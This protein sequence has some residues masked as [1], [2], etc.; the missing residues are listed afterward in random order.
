MR[1]PTAGVRAGRPAAVPRPGLGPLLALLLMATPALPGPLPAQE[2]EIPDR[3]FQ[4][5]TWRNIGPY[6]GGRAVAVHGVP[7]QPETYYMGS[8]GGGV[9]KTTDGG[10]RWRNVSDGFF[11]TGSVGA[12]AVAPSDPNVVYVGMGEHPVRG[13]TT[14]HGDGVYRSTDAGETWTHLGLEGTRHISRIRVHPDDPDRVWVAAQGAVYGPSEE[15]GVYRSRDGGGS[16]EK[17]LYVGETAGASDLAL[18]PTNPRILYAAFWDHL[19][20]PWRVRSGGPG[21]G[22]WKSTDG[23]ETWEPI[24][25]GLPDLMGKTSVDVSPADPDRLYAIVEAE[26]DQGG[27]YR[28][29]DGGRSWR[30]TSDARVIQARSWYYMEVFAHPTD[31]NTVVVLNAPFNLSVDGGRTFTQVEVGHG[32]THDLWINP[33]EPERMILADDGGA[34]ITANGGESWTTLRNQPTAQF[35]RVNADA[36]FPY[37]V[38]GGQQDNSAIGIRSASFGGIGW[39]DFYPVAGCESAY[40]AFDPENPRYVYGNCYQGLIDRWDRESRRSKPV[41]PYPFLGL[42]VDPADQPYRFNWNAPVVADPHD[43]ETI[44]FA[45][46]VVFRTSDRGQSWDVISP[47]LTRDEEE[48]QGPG[49]GPIT[50]EGA[51]GE[52][53]NT[54]MYLEPSP[55]EEGTL[56]AG[57]DDGLVHLTRDGGGNWSEVTP[58]DLPEGMINSIEASPHDPAKAYVVFT[59]YKFDDFTPHVFRTRDYGRSWSRIVDGI[60]A[61][62]AWVRVVREDPE[63]E[64]LLYAGTEVGVYLSFDDGARW[65]EWQLNLPVVPVTDLLVH[66]GDLVASTQGRAFWILDELGPVRQMSA[67]AAGAPVHLFRPEDAHR[68]AWSGGFGG[69]RG[70]R[71]GENPPSGVPIHFILAEAPDSTTLVTLEILEPAGGVVRTYATDPE[72]A[73]DEDFTEIEGL[74]A[75]L[76]TVTWDFRHEPRAAVE[77]LMRYGST[78]GRTASPGIYRIQLTVGETTA[79][80][81]VRLIPDPRWDASDAEYRDQDAF[82]ARVGALADELYEAVNRERRVRDQIESVL[83]RTAGREGADTLRTVGDSLTAALEAWENTVI[84]PKQETFQDVINFHNKLDAQ[85]LHLFGSVDGAEPPVTEGARERLS[86]LEEAWSGRRG[87]FDA[88]M[89]RVAAFNALSRELEIPPV[90]VPG[91]DTG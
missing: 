63:R 9:W 17:V 7:S 49:G 75:G 79:G 78:G 27:L 70:A 91:D 88:L 85:I 47:D 35:Y 24:D 87:A 59:R 34:E 36:Q 45:G 11:N 65:R 86:D 30:Q 26:P 48:K 2:G 68:V 62:G 44:Y 83:E 52:N 81:D 50:N 13:V 37:H 10:E 29:D 61:P 5:L 77:D 73:G 14:S 21:S 25:E 72:A 66:Q 12:I 39:S 89:D 40:L 76:N 46:N 15:R 18:D 60:D 53:Y 4:G 80:S 56:W 22:L 84:Q 90:V 57:S 8:T 6:R 41:Q 33:R 71:E 51:G 23:G 38:Y 67:R 3:A 43:P 28:S 74:E 82:L 31:P 58:P 69:G 42:A 32:D 55:L 20:E 54:I 1:H 64:G 19:R 16:W